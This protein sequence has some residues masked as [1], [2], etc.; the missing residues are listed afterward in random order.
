MSS[1]NRV[2]T[3]ASYWLFGLVNMNWKGF[4][5]DAAVGNGK[6]LSSVFPNIFGAPLRC[7]N[8][9]EC[10]R[11]SQV[12][13]LLIKHHTM[14]LRVEVCDNSMYSLTHHQMDE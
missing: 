12:N 13:P 2:T 7:I 10:K 6:P 3:L 1:D 14:K 4:E 11:E 8:M 5:A 9:V